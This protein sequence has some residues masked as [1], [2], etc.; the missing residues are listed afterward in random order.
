MEVCDHI[1][2]IMQRN[3]KGRVSQ[4]NTREAAHRE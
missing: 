4:H 3:I 2:G 1:I